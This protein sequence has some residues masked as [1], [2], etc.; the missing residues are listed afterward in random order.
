MAKANKV[1]LKTIE[2]Q[3]KA[4]DK[5][6]SEVKIKRDNYMRNDKSY[7]CGDVK[8]VE[9]STQIDQLTKE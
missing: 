7:H 8:H 9:F 2:S 5:S 3:M 1:Q 6:I 4:I